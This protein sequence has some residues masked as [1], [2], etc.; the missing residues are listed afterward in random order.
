MSAQ[1]I[2]VILRRR[3]LNHTFLPPPGCAFSTSS[4]AETDAENNGRPDPS[5][6]ANRRNAY[7]SSLSSLRKAYANEV[8]DARVA[9]ERQDAAA[10]V[11]AARA[12][13]ERQYLKNL[14]SLEGAIRDQASKAQRAVDFARE[15]EEEAARRKVR[16]RRAHR[17]R[18]ILLEE[19]EAEAVHWIVDET[20]A[21]NLLETAGMGMDGLWDRPGALVG[22]APEEA[23]FWKYGCATYHMYPR[24]YVTLSQLVERNAEDYVRENGLDQPFSTKNSKEILPRK[25][26]ELH[27]RE[28]AILALASE[29]GKEEIAALT[30]VRW[31]KKAS[32]P[33][34]NNNNGGIEETHETPNPLFEE[35]G[36]AIE[37]GL[38]IKLGDIWRKVE[39]K[40][41]DENKHFVVP[42]EGLGHV[43]WPVLLGDDSNEFIALKDLDENEIR[44]LDFRDKEGNITEI[45]VRTMFL[46]SVRR[47]L[48]KRKAP[49]ESFEA[50]GFDPNSM[51]INDED[52]KL[53]PADLAAQKEIE[54]L[55]ELGAK[56]DDAA[57][58]QL[59]NGNENLEEPGF[60]DIVTALKWLKE[61]RERDAE[62]EVIFKNEKGEADLD[63]MQMVVLGETQKDT[64]E[65]E[66]KEIEKIELEEM[67]KINFEDSHR[68][69]SKRIEAVEAGNRDNFVTLEQ[70][71]SSTM[72]SSL[73]SKD[74]SIGSDKNILSASPTAPPTR[75][76]EDL[77]YSLAASMNVTLSQ[78]DI[79]EM[80]AA[81]KKLNAVSEIFD[82]DDVVDE[83]EIE[84][85][86]DE[87]LDLGKEMGWTEEEVAKMVRR[88][89]GI[90]ED[91]T[92][93]SK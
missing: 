68:L 1:L 61:T 73:S 84:K 74:G 81:F 75:S 80:K 6:F 16:E 76:T 62:A 17:A 25:A 37:K 13:A 42:E 83:N 31:N 32:G 78:E 8:Y 26:Y 4:V 85:D 55:N 29:K 66:G 18:E 45:A 10:K 34:H 9:A 15:L 72:L 2:H 58:A 50:L 92:N 49:K 63:K 71:D 39:G 27:R 3:C 57:L 24:H 21:E 44:A 38:D 41:L 93:K 48:I 11:V 89:L 47:I 59:D 46:N 53:S 43:P 36:K 54:I 51:I 20:H 70:D 65:I 30:H 23:S 91:D 56:S 60:P 87:L 5:T 79:E 35:Y 64:K 52:A 82:E 22:V 77:L 19:L 88:G 14:A 7:R 12:K 67:E 90:G 33:R 28:S 86:L 40:V 69:E